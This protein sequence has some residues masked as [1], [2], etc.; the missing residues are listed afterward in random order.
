MHSVS[1]VKAAPQALPNPPKGLSAKARAWWK[2]I[3]GKYVLEGHHLALLEQAAA[4]LDRIESAKRAIKVDGEYYTTR[5]GE[6]R[7]HPALAIANQASMLF[8][9]LLRQLD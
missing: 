3:A 7:A 5:L 8:A 1:V 9:K 2:E 4:A 6:H